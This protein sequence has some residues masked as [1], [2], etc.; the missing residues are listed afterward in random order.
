[1]IPYYQV[2]A[3]TG[4]PFGGNPAGV[5]PL[6]NWLS[7]ELMQ[8]IAAE[9]DLS[10]TAFF[11]P[12]AGEFRLRWFAPA[13]EVDLCGHATL[14]TA[15]VL[16]WELGYT[17]NQLVFQTRS[18]QLS[19]LRE[20]E[21]ILMDFPSRPAEPCNARDEVSRALGRVPLEVLK[22]RDYVAVYASAEEVAA[23]EP[24]MARVAELDAL[25]VA[26]TARGDGQADFV[27]RF[28]VPK[29][30]IPE[31]PATGSS[32]CSLIPYWAARLGKTEMFA[33]QLSKRG[34]EIYCRLKGDRV[35]IGGRAAIY[36]RGELAVG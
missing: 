14:A 28:F 9:N 18:G 20:G 29:A 32:H 3:F 24:D 21:R 6:E 11:A 15:Y 10:E 13:M 7:D 1:M 35:E 2:N 4:D 36:C 17:Q 25:G 22:S 12:E 5:C 26:A 27:S 23:L 31:D 8:K 30:G 33:R 16:F 19:A 34:G